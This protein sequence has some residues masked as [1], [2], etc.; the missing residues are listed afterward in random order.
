[1]P[2][3]SP[4]AADLL[5]QLLQRNPENRINITGI[6]QHPFFETIDWDQ[7]L[8]RNLQP[9]FKPAVRSTT[10]ISQIDTDF[11][12]E[13]P[14]ETLVKDSHLLKTTNIENFTYDGGSNFLDR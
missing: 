8:E 7:L 14:V 3:F 4:R 10:D 5:R 6:K 12:N 9:P 11:T 13:A 1:M 2:G